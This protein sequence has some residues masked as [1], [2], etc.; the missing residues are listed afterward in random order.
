MKPPAKTPVEDCLA[1][2]V[3]VLSRAGLLEPGK[4]ARLQLQKGGRDTGSLRVAMW[5]DGLYLEYEV[6]SAAGTRTGVNYVV[7]VVRTPAINQGERVW[8]SCPG[9]HQPVGRLYLPPGKKTFLCRTCNDLTYAS[10]QKRANIWQ[11]VREELPIL[12][13]DL[14]NPR[15]SLARRLK[16]AEGIEELRSRVESAAAQTMNLLPP[17]L[18]SVLVEAR[19]RGARPIPHPATPAAPEAKRARGRPKVKRDYQRREPF[20]E[21]QRRTPTE[22][23]CVKCRRYCEPEECTLV[24]FKNGRPALQGRCPSCGSNVARIVTTSEAAA[25]Y[26]PKAAG[27]RE[28]MNGLEG[29]PMATCAQ[30]RKGDIYACPDCDVE[31]QVIKECADEGKCAADQCKLTCCDKEMELRSDA[32]QQSSWADEAGG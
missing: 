32:L 28:R 21:G 13:E 17:A 15:L 11:K 7:P 30:M 18:R 22:A 23:F 26:Q 1:L 5:G 16:A 19:T 9:C 4:S 10:R 12:K 25:V 8:F 29:G 27:S 6:L 3:L 24:T 2:D 14:L 20:H 31:L